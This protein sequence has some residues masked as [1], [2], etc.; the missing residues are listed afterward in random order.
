MSPFFGRLQRVIAW[1]AWRRSLN[2]R[3]NANDNDLGVVAKRRTGGQTPAV[4]IRASVACTAASVRFVAREKS[5]RA[6]TISPLLAFV[7]HPRI[8]ARGTD[9]IRPRGL[10]LLILR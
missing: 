6:A 3:G 2:V 9:F 7:Y 10:V 4:G 8:L 1:A 5:S